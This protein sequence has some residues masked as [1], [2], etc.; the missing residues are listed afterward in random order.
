MS[1][2]LKGAAR[3]RAE[4]LAPPILPVNADFAALRDAVS[5]LG[6]A[7][8][9]LLEGAG[10]TWSQPP[11]Q[12]LARLSSVR[13][14]GGGAES[15][16]ATALAMLLHEAVASLRALPR[17]GDGM[18]NAGAA[19]ALSEA[20]MILPI[21]RSVV[22]FVPTKTEE[23]TMALLDRFKAVEAASD[24]AAESSRGLLARIEGHGY[25]TSAS[26]VAERTRA[27]MKAEQSA[28]SRIVD[29]NRGNAATLRAMSREIEA[30]IALVNE[31]EEI[32]DR[33]RLIAFNMAV[34]AAHIGDKGRG[35]RV[36]VGE[37]HKINDRTVDFSRRIVALL[38]KY[39]EYSIKLGGEMEDHSKRLNE[40]VV[41][42]IALS[43]EAVETL[44]SSSTATEELSHRLASISLEVRNNL[45][46]VI[47]ALQF[48]D[49]TRQML[50]GALGMMD[51]LGRRLKEAEAV[52]SPPSTSDRAAEQRRFSELQDSYISRVKT[53]EEKIA[54]KEAG[55]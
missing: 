18:Q 24:Q 20:R 38:S 22:G 32:T 49:I 42:G 11:R 55:L 48:Q 37:L 54:I 29:S 10:P 7:L 17:L 52:A 23:A 28:V 3:A 44:I 5:D 21:V 1:F 16:S 33:S 25:S 30:G 6:A 9:E 35:F 40:E 27:A 39:K 19:Q 47:E 13:L 51:D 43:G 14:N 34:E 2:K 15:V 53:K 26:A 46:R 50:E 4:E 8:E 31:I 36:I 41:G 45:D 12:S